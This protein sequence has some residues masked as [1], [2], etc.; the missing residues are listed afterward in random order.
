[1]A[2]TG[3][4]PTHP[5]AAAAESKCTSSRS[6]VTPRSSA[7]WPDDPRLFPTCCHHRN[8][9]FAPILF[10]THTISSVQKKVLTSSGGTPGRTSPHIPGGVAVLSVDPVTLHLPRLPPPLSHSLPRSVASLCPKLLGAT[11]DVSS[12]SLPQAFSLQSSPGSPREGFSPSPPASP[13]A[14]PRRWQRAPGNPSPFGQT[15]RLS[16]NAEGHPGSVG[17][18]QLCASIG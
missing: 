12:A 10:S 4:Q 7:S 5:R 16:M 9:R 11:F 8:L 14:L 2:D 3:C 6:G 18:N 1:M 15:R 13:S 17:W